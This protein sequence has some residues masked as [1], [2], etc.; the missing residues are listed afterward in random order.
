M[1][2]A[3]NRIRIDEF[4]KATDENNNIIKGKKWLLLSN[5][6]N[7]NTEQK[8]FLKNLLSVNRR[9]LKAYLLK[10]EFIKL[11]KYKSY[12]WAM[13]FWQNWK[14]ALRWQ[15]LKPLQK[16]AEMMDNHLEGIMNFYLHKDP[17][18]MGYIEGLNNKIKVLLRKH[19]GFR[20]KKYQKLKIIQVGSKSLKKYIPY[21]WLLSTI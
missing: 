6:T 13:I 3:L 16:F 8:G 15:R 17:L 18:K 7:L 12:K 21:P 9:I 14:K 11:W 1:N 2:K 4:K 10:E 20:D 19:Y 5:R